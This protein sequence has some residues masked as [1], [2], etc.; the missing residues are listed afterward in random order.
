M[1]LIGIR[2]A[3]SLL[4]LFLIVRGRRFINKTFA[5]SKNSS[6]KA[7]D[8]FCVAATADY[9]LHLPQAAEAISNYQFRYARIFDF[10]E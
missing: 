10:R 7:L 8:I 4:A 3:E 2:A 1:P 9:F 5:T 6:R